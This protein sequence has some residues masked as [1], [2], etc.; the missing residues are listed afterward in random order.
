MNSG[1]SNKQ[2]VVQLTEQQ[3]KCGTADRAKAK[4]G[5]ADRVSS[6]VWYSKQ[7]NKQIMMQ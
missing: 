7:S 1:Q 3:T 2:N 4:S 5:T 6:K